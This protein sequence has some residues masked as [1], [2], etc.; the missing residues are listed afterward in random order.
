MVVMFD[1]AHQR[2]V[3]VDHMFRCMKGPLSGSEEHRVARGPPSGLEV[4]DQ[5]K[6]QK[7]TLENI[8]WKPCQMRGI[9][10]DKEAHIF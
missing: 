1:I 9:E 5:V 10:L 4:Y 7:V 6:A 8:R 2:F 3:Q